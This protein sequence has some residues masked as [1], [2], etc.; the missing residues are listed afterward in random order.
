MT[1]AKGE[2]VNE[3]INRVKISHMTFWRRLRHHR[4]PEVDMDKGQSGRILAI[5][6]NPRFDE[7]MKTGL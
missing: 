6:T 4:C 2:R 3:F 1:K 7:F 5:Y